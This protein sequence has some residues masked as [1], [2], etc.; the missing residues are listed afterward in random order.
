MR[1]ITYEAYGPATDVLTLVDVPAQDPGTGEVHVRLAFSA[2]NPSD[3]KRRA[4]ARP[5]AGSGTFAPVCPHSEGSGTIVAAGQGVD[6]ARIGERVWIWNGQFNRDW[7]TA[8]EFIT[9][10]AAQAVPLPEGVSL[11]TGASLGIVGLTAAHTVFGGGPVAGQTLL[12]HGANGSV[13]H[14]AVQ[15]AKWGGANVICT[16]S[17]D[18]FERC[19][20]AGADDVVDYRA[21]EL[22]QDLL[23]ATGGQSF[24]RII[25]VEF[26][27]N[28]QTNAAV[29][30]ENGTLSVYGSAKDMTPR[31]PFGPLL[32]KAV[33]I[34]IVL[35]YILK[36][37]E[38]GAAI[39]QIH[40][41]LE[42]N[43]LSC[44][45]DHVYPLAQT[46]QAH[47]AVEQGSRAGAVLI[48]VTA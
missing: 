42:Q 4:G 38:R 48:D 37:D 33:T 29:I 43:A 32:F 39:A 5:G 22:A 3:V 36:H 18:G 6:P 9:L 45:V 15:L 34:D 40:R 44:P 7:G 46:A 31:I 30:A 23:A 27:Q 21:P 35:I 1:A 2:V 19:R 25:E 47:L 17:P 13:G 20:A 8:A 14:L 24:S 12:I 41:A 16:A 10:P 11:E 26:G 28:I